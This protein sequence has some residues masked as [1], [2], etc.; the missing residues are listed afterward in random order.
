M[1]VYLKNLTEVEE[2]LIAKS[3]PF[4][5]VRKLGKP[6]HSSVNYRHI[7]GHVIVIPE[8]VSTMYTVLP[9][10]VKSLAGTMKVIWVGKDQPKYTDL[11]PY[12]EVRREVVRQAL[13]GL[14]RDNPVYRD[15]EIDEELLNGWAESFIPKELTNSMIVIDDVEGEG[16]EYQGYVTEA[17]DAEDIDEAPE[18]S[19]TSIKL[20]GS[21]EDHVDQ[22]EESNIEGMTELMGTYP[23]GGSVVS[24]VD[25]PS[26][27]V[28]AELAY[29]ISN[30]IKNSKTVRKSQEQ[31]QEQE[32]DQ[33]QEHEHEHEHEQDHQN[34]K[35]Q[36]V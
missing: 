32:Q 9:P 24:N 5:K 19:D 25:G 6:W 29:L 13:F 17:D 22:F 12:L 11:K 7:G 16:E 31:E 8:E 1:P 21:D 36:E 30:S 10:Q 33:E 35:S 23:R 18:G 34:Y 2:M 3:R 28:G 26:G 4:R 15:V 20:N 27:V 14:K